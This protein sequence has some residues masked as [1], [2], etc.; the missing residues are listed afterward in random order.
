[1][2]EQRLQDC[3][4]ARGAEVLTDIGQARFR[5]AMPVR[6]AGKEQQAGLREGLR[7]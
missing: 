6:C 2:S 1:M 4:Q 7:V 5:L 3:I